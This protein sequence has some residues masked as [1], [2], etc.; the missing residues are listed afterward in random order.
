MMEL[1]WLITEYDEGGVDCF[2]PWDTPQEAK[3]EQLE[4]MVLYPG[5]RWFIVQPVEHGEIEK[6]QTV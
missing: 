3:T 2:G 5:D 1:F 6:W 4:M